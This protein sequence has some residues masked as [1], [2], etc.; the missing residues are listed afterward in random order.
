MTLVI[1]FYIIIIPL[2]PLIIGQNLS[3]APLAGP[4]GI[5]SLQLFLG[6]TVKSIYLANNKHLFSIYP[7]LQR[8]HN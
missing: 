6:V 4:L 5:I 1:L 8:S 2:F 7:W 3:I